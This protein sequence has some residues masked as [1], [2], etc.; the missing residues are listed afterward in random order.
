MRQD[1][2]RHARTSGESR[3]VR[4]QIKIFLEALRVKDV[5]AAEAEYR[6]VCS[7]LDK[8]STSTMH[9][10]TAARKKSRLAARLNTLKAA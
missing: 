4:E 10:N 9:K 3:E 7:I 2:K 6:K 5:T 1:K 8:A